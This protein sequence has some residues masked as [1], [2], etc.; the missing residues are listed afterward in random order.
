MN[1]Q[2]GIKKGGDFATFFYACYPGCADGTIPSQT[3]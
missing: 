3:W 1:H 2:D